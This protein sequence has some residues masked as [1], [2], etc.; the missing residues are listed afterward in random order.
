MGSNSV[1]S[2]CPA[3]KRCVKP[4]SL[5]FNPCSRPH[6]VVGGL[7]RRDGI[8][9]TQTMAQVR[10]YEGIVILHPDASEEEQ[11][12]LFRKNSEIIKSFNGEVNHLDTWGRRKLANPIEKITRGNYFHITFTARGDAVAE[13]ERTMRINDRVLRFAHT[14]LDDRVSLAKYVEDFKNSLTETLKR[15]SEREAKAQARRQQA[16]QARDSGMREMTGGGG[17]RR[18]RDFDG[19]DDVDME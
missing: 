16:M 11:K 15:E 12:T 5:N 13:L 7:N 1:L 9:S 17:G 14:R 6:G 19:M 4:W 8:V 2:S 10:K 3:G 18:G